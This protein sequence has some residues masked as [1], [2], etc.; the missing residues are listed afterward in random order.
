[1]KSESNNN[2][3]RIAPW[4]MYLPWLLACLALGSTISLAPDR[5]ADSQSEFVLDDNLIN[6]PTGKSVGTSDK[7][8]NDKPPKKISSARSFASLLGKLDTVALYKDE[9]YKKLK[10]QGYPIRLE[11]NAATWKSMLNV[12][13]RR[14]FKRRPTDAVIQFG[15][16]SRQPA[17]I[18]LRGGGSL[19]MEGKP[20]FRVRM[21]RK[22][23]FTKN[24]K[25]KK[26]YLMNMRY[27]R[28][29]YQIAWTYNM[30]RD[31]DMFHL[32]TQYI[33][34]IVNGESL[35]MFMMIEPPET[36]IRRTFDDVVAIHRRKR[37]N[38]YT[39]E[40]SASVPDAS[41]S[42][43]Q[44]RALNREDQV[45]NAL[46]AYSQVID[47]EQYF[48]WL[49]INS[50]LQNHDYLDE[51]FFF[52]RRTDKQ[53]SQPLQLMAWDYDDVAMD[54]QKSGHVED[55]HFWSA[56]DKTDFAIHRNPELFARYK[57]AL[58]NMLVEMP[59]ARIEKY[60][61]DALDHRLTLDDGRS[62]AKQA[63]YKKQAKEIFQ[64]H[65]QLLKERHA[66]LRDLLNV[67]AQK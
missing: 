66:Y 1:V 8:T 9:Q 50:I 38:V 12:D 6:Q 43:N 65:L 15:N 28:G 58:A 7:K 10:D 44:L 55:P 53:T 18:T 29:Q 51:P 4:R 67:K 11:F 14:H 30:L 5:K 64:E 47:I 17:I 60:M 32:H 31:F 25:L 57:T 24:V 39:S 40:W 22:E 2:T 45:D 33:R 23:A 35:G 62:P 13:N 48:R 46:E 36:G 20:N 63:A 3:I 61:R 26:F 56:L 52:E 21:I 16:R 49:A 19:G 42:L 34:I 54:V 59:A 27:D 41:K 37:S